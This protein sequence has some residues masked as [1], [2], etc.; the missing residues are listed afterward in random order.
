MSFGEHLEELRRRVLL[1]MAV[2]LP[3]SVLTFLASDILIRWLVLPLTRVLEWADLPPVVQTLSPPEMLVTK[4]KLSLIGAVVVSAPWILWQGWR[5][6]AP[7]LYRTERRFVYFLVPGSAIL[8]AAGIALMY[9][10]MLPLML[11]VLV[12]VS[13]SLDLAPDNPGT[14]PRVQANLALHDELPIRAAAPEQPAAGDAWLL[15]PRLELFVAVADAEAAGGVAVLEVPPR[16]PSSVEQQFRVS[17]YIGFVLLLFLGIVLAFQMPL[18]IALLGWLGLASPAWLRANR[19]YALMVCAAVSALITPADALSMLMMLLPL[20]GLYELGIVFLVIAP[21]S[22]VAEGRV[23]RFGRAPR[24]ADNAEP[25]KRSARI[26]QP[27]EPA[28]TEGTVPR[29]R[30][31][32]Q[33]DPGATD[34]EEGDS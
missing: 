13:T 3:L 14:D 23:F 20:Y 16:L 34:G 6:I 12:M 24:T 10:V 27:D 11:Q 33:S 9:W 32:D 7:G 15:W 19:K 17:E 5:F 2:P 18:V 30:A 25:D 1:A 21:S 28:Q 4:I 26:D 22:A 31:P 8:T 29:G